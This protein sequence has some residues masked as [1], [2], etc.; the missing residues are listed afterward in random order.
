MM[1]SGHHERSLAGCMP[2][3]HTFPFKDLSLYPLEAQ[4]LKV[5]KENSTLEVVLV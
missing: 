1:A 3:N 2:E 4:P 5:V